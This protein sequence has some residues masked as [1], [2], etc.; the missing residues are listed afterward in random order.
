MISQINDIPPEQFCNGDNRPPNCGPNCVCTHKVDI[1]LN[2]IV[3]VVLVDEVQQ[4]NLSHPFHLHGYSFNV[5]GMGRS[6][7]TT[8]KKI[9]LKHALDLDRRGLLHRE[10]S[11]PPFKDT[12]A[13]PNNGY[14]VIRFRADNPGNI[15][16]K[17]FQLVIST[18][19]PFFI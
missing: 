13:V 18:K 2:A 10:F 5:I 8:V 1:P 11:L 17:F 7:D 3:E 12:I 6:P 16:Y 14:V 9:N 4:T 15:Y 19:I